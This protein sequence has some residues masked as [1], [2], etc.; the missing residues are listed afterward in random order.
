MADITD[1]NLALAILDQ[2]VAG[3]FNGK[4]YAYHAVINDNG[5]TLG[6]AV[7][8]ERGYNPIDGL[9]YETESEAKTVANGM[10]GHIG[11]SRDQATDIVIS[12]MRG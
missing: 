6:I 10:N 12:T 11:L 4:A 7:K 2:K 5:W 9:S 8:D 1:N 3:A